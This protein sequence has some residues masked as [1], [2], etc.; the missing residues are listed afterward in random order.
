MQN[1]GLHYGYLFNLHTHAGKM[2]DITY[3]CPWFSQ[4]APSLPC[5]TLL[6]VTLMLPSCLWDIIDHDGYNPGNKAKGYIIE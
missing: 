3:I 6:L 2:N 4:H 5:F 1:H